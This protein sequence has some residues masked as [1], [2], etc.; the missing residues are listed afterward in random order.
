MSHEIPIR[1]LNAPRWM[2][3]LGGAGIMFFGQMLWVLFT[4]WAIGPVPSAANSMAKYSLGI[5]LIGGVVVMPFIETLAGQW[6]PIQMVRRLFRSPWWIA[7]LASVIVF[8]VSHGYTGRFAVTIL[9]GAIV[10][11]AI[12][13]IETKR[14][15]RP[16]L[17]TYLTH[18]AANSM[19]FSLQFL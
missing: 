19:V 11:S 8:T 7:G 3:I 13:V 17:C 18:A 1:L 6:L 14:N 5:Q 4:V 10:L 2:L 16:I 15:G 12:F 9:L